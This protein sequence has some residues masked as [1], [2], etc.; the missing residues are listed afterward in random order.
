MFQK[1]VKLNYED[2]FG[3]KNLLPKKWNY[4]YAEVTND[5]TSYIS[6]FI[7]NFQKQTMVFGIKY[8]QTNK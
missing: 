7:V 1:M 2:V 5:L 4:K 3:A 8:L 6:S